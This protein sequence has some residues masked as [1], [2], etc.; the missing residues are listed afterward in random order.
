MTYITMDLPGEY[1]E[2]S[3]GHHYALTVICIL[4]SF[5]DVIPIEDKKTDTV[6]KA[7]LKYVYADKGGSKF[8]LTDRGSKFSGEV[9]SYIADQ[10]GFTK[11]DTLPYSPK[12][13]S[14]IERCHSFLKNSIRNMGCNYNAEWD[15]LI[16]I[17]KMAYNIFPHSAAGESLF[18]LMYE[19]DAYLPTLH[20][21]LQPKMQHMADGK[22]RIH[23]DSMQE[24]YM[25][26][27]LK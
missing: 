21:L 18:F 5:V 23:F 25:M 10:L 26:A 11:V 22:C 12:S 19:R 9:I 6:I 15:E 8:I 1:S 2:T 27:V 3:Q 20:Q 24:M 7:Y 17:A 13:K 4:T 14:I 16:H